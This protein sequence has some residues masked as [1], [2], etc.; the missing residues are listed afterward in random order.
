MGAFHDGHLQLM[1]KAKEEN[2]QVV[3]SLFVNPTQFGVGEDFDRYPRDLERDSELAR[4]AGVDVLFTPTTNEIY[5]R[6]STTVQ[7]PDVGER[8]EGSVRPTHFAGV[9]TVVCKLLNIVRC[10]V[11]YFGQKDLQQCL[12]IQRMIDDLNIRVKFS[13]QPTSREP[14]G[15]AMSSRN[16]YLSPE[17]RELAPQLYAQLTACRDRLLSSELNPT[18]I[19]DELIARTRKL[20]EIGFDVD[21]FELIDTE[22]TN[23]LRTVGGQGA[24]IVAARI[25]STRLIDNVIL[26]W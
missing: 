17:H 21:Y 12:V 7:V 14:D 9:A 20:G 6:L 4:S 25:G 22:N 16:V 5:P 8:W 26:Q 11:A 3:V 18:E 19:D 10:D 15:L 24:L 13:R 23:P 1:R 2:D